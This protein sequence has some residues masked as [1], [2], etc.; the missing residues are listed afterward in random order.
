MRLACIYALLDRSQIICIHHRQAAL[1]LWDYAFASAQF[2]FEDALGDAVAD[3]ILRELRSHP[4][5]LTSTQISRIFSKNIS[6]Q[7]IQTALSTL[8]Q[9]NLIRHEKQ[10]KASGK[11]G[12]PTEMW[13]A[14][15]APK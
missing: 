12:R 9:M 2:I 1:A 13:F 15:S 10:E 8:L 14:V 11:Q 4:N 3:E 5:G 6:A 7:R